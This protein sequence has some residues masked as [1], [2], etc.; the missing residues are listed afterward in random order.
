MSEYI[1]GKAALKLGEKEPFSNTLQA[2]SNA[3][4]IAIRLTNYPQ[5]KPDRKFCFSDYFELKMKLESF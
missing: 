3:F 2:A 1:G 4:R 5:K